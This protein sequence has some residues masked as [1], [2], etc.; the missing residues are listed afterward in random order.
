[1][2]GL[3]YSALYFYIYLTV[4]IIQRKFHTSSQPAKDGLFCD[5][6]LLDFATVAARGS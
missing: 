3:I 4:I 6:T 1:M 2:V 5:L